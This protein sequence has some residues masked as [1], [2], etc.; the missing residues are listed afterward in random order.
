VRRAIAGRRGSGQAGAELRDDEV[1][2]LVGGRHIAGAGRQ[3]ESPA[4]VRHVRVAA[5]GVGAQLPASDGPCSQR[6]RWCAF[7]ALRSLECRGFV[8][9]HRGQYR[10]TNLLNADTAANSR[11]A[12]ALAFACCS[13]RPTRRGS[14][15]ASRDGR[16]VSSWRRRRSR[17]TR[18]RWPL[19]ATRTAW[20]T[21]ARA[22]SPPRP[23]GVYQDLR[24]FAGLVGPL[25]LN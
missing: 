15:G 10:L 24:D 23:C 6:A 9:R 21:F 17:P 22:S 8:R 3:P 5:I 4:T 16:L 2:I 12:D 14:P 1:S 19:S 7:P 13:P 11:L 18:P 20:A 25:R